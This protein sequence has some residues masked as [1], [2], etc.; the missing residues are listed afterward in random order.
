M[1]NPPFYGLQNKKLYLN[2]LTKQPFSFCGYASSPSL[3]WEI[4]RG[5]ERSVVSHENSNGLDNEN[6][7][8]E[9]PFPLSSGY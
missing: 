1:W 3:D 6:H 4:K 2:T 9:F 5:K 7:F 8:L